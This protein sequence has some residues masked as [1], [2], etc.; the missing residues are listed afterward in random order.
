MNLKEHA[1]RLK[2]I[3]PWED[4]N[5]VVGYWHLVRLLWCVYRG[6]IVVIKSPG[7]I[8]PANK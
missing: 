8:K 3:K 6:E 4:H 1:K 7:A 5:V 2:A